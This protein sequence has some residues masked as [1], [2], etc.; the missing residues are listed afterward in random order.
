MHRIKRLILDQGII[1]FTFI[2]TAFG[3]PSDPNQY[4]PHTVGN[5]WRWVNSDDG[6]IHDNVITHDSTGSDSSKYLFYNGTAVPSY[7][8]D[9]LNQVYQFL[10]QTDSHG[11]VTL[12][13][14]ILLHRLNAQPS[15]SFYTMNNSF[16]VK[17]TAYNSTMFG[18]STNVKVFTWYSTSGGSEFTRIS[19][20]YGFG[21]IVTDGPTSY[22]SVTGCIINGVNYGSLVSVSSEVDGIPDRYK[23]NQNY[24]NPFN[25]S[26]TISYLVSKTAWVSLKIYNELGQLVATLVDE[27]KAVGS[28]KVNWTPQLPS[29]I[30]FYQL[31]SDRFLETKKLLL[32]K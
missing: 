4:F 25:P 6:S 26:T 10:N 22:V 7:R 20:A 29:G 1:C 18:H 11:H 8:L 32:L 27:R 30:Y 24:P 3:Q 31:H 13:N 17:V 2:L 21:P 15:D 14:E 23:L 9:T 28:Y 16:I 19:L 5:K 12:G